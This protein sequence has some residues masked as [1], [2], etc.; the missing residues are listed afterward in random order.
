MNEIDYYANKS[1]ISNFF[2]FFLSY[3]LYLYLGK[4]PIF[5]SLFQILGKFFDSDPQ[6]FASP[7]SGSNINEID[8]YF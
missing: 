1:L 5:Y 6:W 4:A 8:F 7:R 2:M 3:L